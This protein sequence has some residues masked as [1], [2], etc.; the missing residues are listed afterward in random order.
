[1]LTPVATAAEMAA[2]DQRTIE[3]FGLPGVCLMENAGARVVEAMKAR[4][5]DLRGRPIRLLAGKGNNGGDAFVAARH[6]ANLG[7]DVAVYLL[8]APEEARG[9]V[10][11]HLEVLR[12]MEVPLHLVTN[13]EEVRKAFQDREEAIWVDGVFG[14]G[15]DSEPRGHIAEALFA[16]GSKGVPIVAIDIPSG[17]H[18]DTGRALRGALRADLTV[19]FGLP[20]RGQLL[21]PGAEHVGEFVV[22]DIGIPEEAVKAQGITTYLLDAPDVRALFPPVSPNAHKGT[23]GHVLVVAGSVGKMGAAHLATSA[24]LRMGGGLVTLAYPK[25]AEALSSAPAEAMT[26]PLPATTE[27]TIAKGAVGRVLEMAER[28]DAVV[29]G[30]GLTTQDETV[31][32]VK[33]LVTKC[34]RSMVVDADGLN[35]LAQGFEGWNS[36]P[37]P[38]CLTPHP[39]EMGRLVGVETGEVQAD[40]VE[41]CRAFSRSRGV[42]LVLKGAGTLIATPQGE[43]FFNPTGNPGLATGG[44]GDVLA[45]AIGALLGQGLSPKEALIV[46][47]YTH[48][49]AGDLGAKEVGVRG[50]LASDVLDRLPAARQVLLE[51]SKG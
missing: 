44:S 2:I 28:V 3:E 6:L 46:G 43:V 8:C 51:S 32:F 39:G 41:T 50:L 11:I 14:T 21:Y 15:L 26:L 13:E 19:T 27:G 29:L 22:A 5:S 30:P 25:D 31:S 49:L 17:V 10:R 4:Y 37:A 42:F 35:G 45:G 1:M 33:E 24:V 20:K 12:R 23:F 40:R 7:A 36:L 38:R 48:G 34:S 47:V 18:A 16:L 9:D